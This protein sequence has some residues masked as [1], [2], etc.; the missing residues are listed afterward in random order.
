[1]GIEMDKRKYKIILIEK[2]LGSIPKDLK[3]FTRYVQA[4]YYGKEEDLMDA[5][6]EQL[7][8]QEM[9]MQIEQ[10]LAPEGQGETGFYTDADGVYLMDYHIKGFLKEAGNVLKDILK[11]KNLR[12]KI[13]NYVF[14]FPRYIWLKEKPDGRLERSLRANTPQGPRVSLISSDFIDPVEFEIEIALL[15]HKELNWKVIETLL[16]YGK[17][18]GLGQ[19]RN[20]GYGRFTWERVK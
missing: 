18:K 5:D 14:V 20:G 2:L 6:P 16:D 10:K 13:D 9:Q 7:D 19:W 3:V 12:S 17:L 1:M 15:P 4:K 11:I 8:E